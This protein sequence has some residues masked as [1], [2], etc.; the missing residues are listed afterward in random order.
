MSAMDAAARKTVLV[1]DDEE[2]FHVATERHLR[3]YNVIAA[4]SARQAQQAVEAHRVD[5]ALVDLNLPDDNGF[6]LTAQLAAR[7]NAPAIIVV[8]SHA[9]LSNV[10][11]AI[12]AGAF[13]FFDK[14]D[15]VATLPVCIDQA[16]AGAEP[17]PSLLCPEHPL[18]A[19]RQRAWR[20]SKRRS[21]V[22]RALVASAQTAFS[23]EE[24]GQL[25]AETRRG[26]GIYRVVRQHVARTVVRVAVEHAGGNKRAAADLLGV[27]YS[28]IFSQE[29]QG[30]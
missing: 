15:D 6:R 10:I 29:D 7:P 23:D 4:F 13:G 17:I 2:L 12:K 1:V 22:A 25:V 27:S 8:S 30:E 9:T 11:A 20:A 5:V 26:R 3:P 19:G 18:S 16:I 14:G 21:L 28:T 24:L